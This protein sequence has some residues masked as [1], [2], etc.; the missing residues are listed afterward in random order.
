MKKLITLFFIFIPSISQAETFKSELIETI[1]ISVENNVDYLPEIKIFYRFNDKFYEEKIDQ[2]IEI[3]FFIAS[4][5]D[6]IILNNKNKL[7]IDY[8]FKEH[9]SFFYQKNETECPLALTTRLSVNGI[10]VD[11]FKKFLVLENFESQIFINEDFENVI[12]K[13]EEHHAN[14][15]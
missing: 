9:T 7:K 3:E 14:D 4:C 5:S 2:K 13:L 12:H 1:N 6:I 10:V 11:Q 8:L 15:Q